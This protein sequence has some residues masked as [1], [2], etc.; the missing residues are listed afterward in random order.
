MAEV[1]TSIE[2]KL[3]FISKNILQD[4]LIDTGIC[5]ISQRIKDNYVSYEDISE[6]RYNEETLQKVLDK[7]NTLELSTLKPNI[8]RAIQEYEASEYYGP[9][10]DSLKLIF[11]QKSAVDLAIK[12]FIVCDKTIKPVNVANTSELYMSNKTSE[13]YMSNKT[14]NPSLKNTTAQA[15][16]DLKLQESI[17]ILTRNRGASLEVKLGSQPDSKKDEIAHQNQP[18]NEEKLKVSSREVLDLAESNEL[19][20]NPKL[21]STKTFQVSSRSNSKN[22]DP[23]RRTERMNTSSS[24]RDKNH[25]SSSREVGKLETVANGSRSRNSSFSRERIGVRERDASTSA[26]SPKTRVSSRFKQNDFEEDSHVR[27]Y[28]KNHHKAIE[29]RVDEIMTRKKRKEAILKEM[30]EQPGEKGWFRDACQCAIW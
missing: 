21:K 5:E 19:Q 14:L 3:D 2:S 15:V 13:L 25:R 18:K 9:L 22:P 27:Q 29:R 6:F 8:N 4:Y 23:V 17:N 30:K 26:K 16:A 20:D 11:L 1:M 28:E 24:N 7:Y 12:N 10:M